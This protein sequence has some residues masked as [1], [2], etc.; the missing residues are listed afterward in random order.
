MRAIKTKYKGVLFRSKLEAQWAKFFDAIAMPWIYEPEGYVFEDGTTYLPDFFLPD[1]KQWFE[2]K[3]VMS[4]KD[5]HKIKMLCIESGHDVVIGYSD[6]ELSMIDMFFAEFNGGQPEE[7]SWGS[8]NI[9]KCTQCGKLSFMN[10]VGSYT[11][12]CCGAYDGDHFVDWT[13]YGREEWREMAT[14]DVMD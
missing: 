8:I 11:C 13:F 6:G 3:G 10:N 1:S 5:M 9:N 2:V 12:Q 4:N 7:Y 14:I